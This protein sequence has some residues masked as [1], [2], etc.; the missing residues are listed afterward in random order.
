MQ[1]STYENLAVISISNGQ[2]LQFY[3]EPLSTFYSEVVRKI[4]YENLF[5]YY[6][7]D[8]LKKYSKPFFAITD[9]LVIISNSPGTVQR[10]LND[11]NNER[12]LSNN[13]SFIRFDHLVADQSNVSFLMQLGNSENLF[14]TLLKKKYFPIFNSKEYGFEEFYGISYQLTSNK[15]Y[16]F[17]NV[18][19]GYK[20]FPTAAADSLINTKVINR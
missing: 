3:L 2:Q 5:Y 16:F 8:P 12:L 4:D 13:T 19:S 6:F 7:G 15:D 10:F 14:K 9:N 18:Y 1:L 11:Y 17:T 20:N